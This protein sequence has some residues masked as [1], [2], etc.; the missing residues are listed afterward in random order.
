[1]SRKQ[2]TNANLTNNRIIGMKSENTAIGQGLTGTPGEEKG[3]EEK[4]KKKV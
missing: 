2:K 4:K 3:E 1:L